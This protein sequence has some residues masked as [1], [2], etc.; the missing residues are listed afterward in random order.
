MAFGQAASQLGFA[1]GAGEHRACASERERADLGRGG[2]CLS[3]LEQWLC[4][5]ER[6]LHL[7]PGRGSPPD[8]GDERPWTAGST[9]V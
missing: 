3:G 9:L 5:G 6:S 4:E 7:R 1:A 2:A 8:E